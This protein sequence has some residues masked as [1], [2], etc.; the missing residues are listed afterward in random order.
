LK[1][2][3]M[4]AAPSRLSA[5]VPLTGPIMGWSRTRPNGDRVVRLWAELDTLGRNRPEAMLV[6]CRLIDRAGALA[7]EHYTC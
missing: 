2:L 6:R 3:K 5:R 1:T 4:G 7:R